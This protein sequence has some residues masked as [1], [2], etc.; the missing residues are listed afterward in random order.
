[1]LIV[2]Y[3]YKKNVN[4]QQKHHYFSKIPS[5]YLEIVLSID[6]KKKILSRSYRDVSA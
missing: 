2:F 3:F 4:I 1:M 5:I 6:A